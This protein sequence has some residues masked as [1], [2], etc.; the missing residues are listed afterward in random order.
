MFVLIIDGA[1]L[2]RMSVHFESRAG[3]NPRDLRDNIVRACPLIFFFL[4]LM[5]IF[6]LF[7]V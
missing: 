5:I 7:P 4:C 2:K 1:D 6:I 3:A